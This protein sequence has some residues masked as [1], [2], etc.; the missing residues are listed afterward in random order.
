MGGR[1]RRR[2]L[3]PAL[4]GALAGREAGSKVRG[5]EEAHSPGPV[6]PAR[7]KSQ[8]PE[9]GPHLRPGEGLT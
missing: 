5:W 2:E 4:Q 8:L 9:K 3:G 6:P 1:G 7:V